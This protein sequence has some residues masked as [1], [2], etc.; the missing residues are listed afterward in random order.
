MCHIA[1]FGIL[2]HCSQMGIY[3]FLGISQA[4]TGFL[5]GT[6]IALIVYAASRRLHH[7]S[8]PLV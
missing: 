3:A 1:V 2:P 7:V 5:N 6:I 4:F 8:S